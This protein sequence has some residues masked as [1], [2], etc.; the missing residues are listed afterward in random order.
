MLGLHHDLLLSSMSLCLEW[1]NYPVSSTTATAE[2]MDTKDGPAS[3][4]GN[5]ITTGTLESE[6][7]IYSIDLLNS[8]YPDAI[9]SNPK[10]TTAHVPELAG[11]GK[12]KHKKSKHCVANEA[13]HVNAI[14]SL[15]WNH[16]VQ[17]I[18]TSRSTDHTVKLWDLL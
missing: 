4:F 6:T 1:L 8:I 3:H 11:M 9:L 14:L 12:K 2:N 5:Y 13:H 15:S 10:E 16:T 17:Q 7:E 18:L